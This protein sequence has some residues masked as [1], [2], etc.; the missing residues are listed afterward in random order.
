VAAGQSYTTAAQ[1]VGRRS[2]DAVAHLVARASTGKGWRPSRRGTVVV[3]PDSMGQP[4]A[5]AFCSSF[6]GPRTAPVMERRGGRSQPCKPRCVVPQM[7]SRRSAPTP[8]GACYGRLGTPGN[9]TGRGVQ[10]VKRCA[11]VRAALLPSRTPMRRQKNV[12]RAGLHAG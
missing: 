11:S 7:A 6:A 3:A 5:T 2:N 9:A 1:A 12:D 8:S 4:N 10:P